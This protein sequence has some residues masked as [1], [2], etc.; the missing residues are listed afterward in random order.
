MKPQHKAALK[1]IL[2]V[3]SIGV[4]AFVVWEIIKAIKAGEK[5]L[6]GIMM[7]PFTALQSVWTGITGMF[8]STPALAT[9]QP[10]PILNAA[11]QTVAT[12]DPSS[13]LYGL[14]APAD[15]ANT[16]A[17]ANYLLNGTSPSSVPA[18]GINWATYPTS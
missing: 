17:L 18:S 2:I 3:L 16:Q 15:Q 7:A 6:A 8:S 10:A 14:V 9:P 13:P 11:G 5:T 1:Q 12:V 4:F